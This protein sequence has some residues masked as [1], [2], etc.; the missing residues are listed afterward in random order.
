M[1]AFRLLFL[2]LRRDSSYYEIFNQLDGASIL[3]RILSNRFAQMN[4]TMCQV[5]FNLL[6][7]N[8]F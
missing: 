6:L 4:L 2:C 1:E 3:V 5:I 8:S 7:L